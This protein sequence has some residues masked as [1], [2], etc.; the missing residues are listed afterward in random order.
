M[1]NSE[2]ACGTVRMP[3]SMLLPDD[4]ALEARDT[5]GLCNGS[6]PP[7]MHHAW[8]ARCKLTLGG[9]DIPAHV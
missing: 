2:V 4:G 7:G 5:R 1:P 9:A 6:T 8:L 3:S